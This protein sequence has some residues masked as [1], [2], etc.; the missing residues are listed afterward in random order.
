MGLWTNTFSYVL[1][2]FRAVAR[3][4]V[5]FQQS[6]GYPNAR[7]QCFGKT[8]VVNPLAAARRG[9][10]GQKCYAN[11]VLQGNVECAFCT[12]L[13]GMGNIRSCVREYRSLPSDNL[14]PVACLNF[15][16][17]ARC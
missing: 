9:A 10:C 1:Y 11:P 5:L 13:K 7:S 6:N 4:P 14:I 12:C 3:Y 8:A 17:W 2:L 16:R 15:S